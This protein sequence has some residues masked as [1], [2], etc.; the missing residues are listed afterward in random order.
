MADRPVLAPTRS[1]AH[2]RTMLQRRA[3]MPCAVKIAVGIPTARD[4]RGLITEEALA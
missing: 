4:L 1:V 2:V 3:L